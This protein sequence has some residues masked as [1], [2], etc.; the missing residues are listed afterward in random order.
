ME[1][2]LKDEI[3]DAA[4]NYQEKTGLSMNKLAKKL[5][6]NAAT[7]SKVFSRQ[8][9]S[10][11]D[12]MFR[13]IAYGVGFLFNKWNTALTSNL[14]DVIELCKIAQNRKISFGMAD[15]AGLGKTEGLEYYAANNKNTYYL[16]CSFQWTHKVFLQKMAQCLGL[17][18]SGFKVHEL[19]EIV[20]S[21]IKRRDNALFILDEIDKLKEGAFLYF[22][23]LYNELDGKCGFILSGSP[24]IIKNMRV[25]VEK[26][27]RGY[28]EIWSRIGQRW[29]TLKAIS[30]SDVNSVARAN[31]IEETETIHEIYNDCNNDFRRV[32]RKIEAIHEKNQKNAA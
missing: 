18:F 31:G 21:E 20:I 26:D 15:R 14:S 17:E 11:S 19:A 25:G 28:Q 5:G 1:T 16:R 6:I 8:Y 27:K 4:E 9:E 32:K 13:K 10:I 30:K 3:K 29:I 12:E 24:Y 23:D 22:I 7:I 2:Y